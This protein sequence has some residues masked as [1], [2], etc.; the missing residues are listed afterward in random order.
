MLNLLIDT[1]PGMGLVG[2][3]IDDNLAIMWAL[4]SSEVS[5]KGITLTYGNVSL[6]EAWLSLSATLRLIRK[7]SVPVALG[8]ERPLIKP[9]LN[10]RDLKKII[11][12]RKG[13]Q[14]NFDNML[15]GIEP[16]NPVSL[17]A[18][19]FILN[20]AD[21][22]PDL[23]ILALGPLTNIAIAVKTSPK[24]IYKIKELV[25]MGGALKEYGNIT[26]VSEF[27]I[28]CDPEAAEI[29]FSSGLPITV[30]GLDV[31]HRVQ[32][33]LEDMQRCIGSEED[34][35]SELANFVLDC[36][37]KWIEVRTVFLG[38]TFF[39]PHDV[40]AFA[41]LLY[42]EL[43]KK[44]QMYLKVECSGMLTRGKIIGI[45]PEWINRYPY[46]DLDLEAMRPVNVCIEIN[47]D[48]FFQAFCKFLSSLNTFF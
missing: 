21:K 38:E 5:L 4:L 31:T 11:A 27:N 14:I 37:R 44:E 10:S 2:S 25:I 17:S 8:C 22:C 18:P 15:K 39:Y 35:K 9:Y 42:P 47:R 20:T 48:A 19:E 32:V 30:I 36:A 12:E 1:D 33:Y 41:Y 3:D 28:F 23:V 16:I 34:P 40:I 13:F 7:T 6:Q 45:R 43:F 24:V 26:P 29:V 46:T